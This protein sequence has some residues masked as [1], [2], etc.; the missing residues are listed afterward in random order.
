MNATPCRK[1][2]L[3]FVGILL[4][5]AGLFFL[6][7]V[8]WG[9]GRLAVLGRRVGGEV[10]EITEKD[11]F[12]AP[13]RKEGERWENYR[14]RRQRDKESGK[15][16]ITRYTLHVRFTPEGGTPT[17]FS[18]VST[19]GLLFQVGDPVRVLYLPADPARAEIDSPMQL[20]QLWMPLGVGIAVG[21]GCLAGGGFLLRQER[22]R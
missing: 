17:D 13:S 3:L 16:K 8:I 2:G 10:V 11:N 21:V 7:V 22:V 15:R 19:S 9:P 18:T 4:L 14:E 6:G 5:A 1:S 12:I 20:W